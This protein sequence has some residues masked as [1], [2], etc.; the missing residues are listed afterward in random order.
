[1]KILHTSDLHLGKKL[2]GYDLCEEQKVKLDQMVQYIK[3]N[4]IDAIILAGDIFDTSLASDDAIKLFNK[5][6][7]ELILIDKLEIFVIAGN[8]DSRVRLGNKE[9]YENLNGRIH[10]ATTINDIHKIKLGNVVFSLIPFLRIDDINNFY[11]TDYDSLTEAYNRV[12]EELNID[13]NNINICIAHQAVNPRNGQYIAS[14]SEVKQVGGEDVISSI[15]FNDF[16]YVALGHIHMNQ[17]IEDNIY[18]SGSIYKYHHNEAMQ[19][20]N[21]IVYDTETKE[22]KKVLF[23]IIKDVKVKNGY[24]QEL[25]QE[26]SNDYIYFKLKD[27][28]QILHAADG[29][30][31]N[32][33]SFLGLEYINEQNEEELSLDINVENKSYLELFEEFYFKIKEKELSPKQIEII[34][35]LFKE[36]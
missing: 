4:N 15:I 27:S 10:F 23:N 24:Y 25:M 21:F 32:Y 28:E 9:V 1:M 13:K 31:T 5:F 3:D 6:L 20:R 7:K 11:H 16:D 19:A 36:D 34:K 22:I 26:K 33:P 35:D 17:K 2:N 14:D 30:K 29:L 8:H 18:Y 12:I